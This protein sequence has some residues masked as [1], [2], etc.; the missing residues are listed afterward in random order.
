MASRSR[1]GKLMAYALS[2]AINQ[3]A[4]P[5]SIVSYAGRKSA[6]AYAAQQDGSRF[7]RV[8]RKFVSLLT[9]KENTYA[10]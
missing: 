6:C 2:P 1:G 9:G 5:A 10:S 4:S 3:D 8:M 7:V